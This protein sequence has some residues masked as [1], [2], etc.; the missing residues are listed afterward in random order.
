MYRHIFSI[1][2]LFLALAALFFYMY[3]PV[4]FATVLDWR[5]G[6]WIGISFV[7]FVLLGKVIDDYR[8]LTDIVNNI[9]E[10]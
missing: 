2:Y 8:R 5:Y 7:N 10:A 4:N 9:I 6:L 3:N 1:V